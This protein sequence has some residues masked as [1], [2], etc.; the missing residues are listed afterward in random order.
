M[1]C[2]NREEFQSKSQKSGFMLMELLVTFACFSVIIFSLTTMYLKIQE[3][4]HATRHNLDALQITTN[5][6][7]QV[8]T[9][10]RVQAHQEAHDPFIVTVAIASAPHSVQLISVT[11]AAKNNPAMPL[12]TLT[13]G[14]YYA[15][16]T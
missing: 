8:L 16:Q 14:K 10:T 4:N 1:L 11:C 5:V 9:S 12:V 6:L 3:I 15:T 2:F 13:S 7:E